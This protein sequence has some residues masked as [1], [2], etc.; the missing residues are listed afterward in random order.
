MQ[1]GLDA[2][3]RPIQSS[4]RHVTQRRSE[5]AHS[6]ESVTFLK[7]FQPVPKCGGTTCLSPS[8]RC[9]AAGCVRCCRSILLDKSEA[10]GCVRRAQS[11]CHLKPAGAR[12]LKPAGARDSSNEAARAASQS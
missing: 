8:T 4:R 9:I 12:D 2:K 3:E 10:A 7:R 1:P 11:A 5:R 6:Q